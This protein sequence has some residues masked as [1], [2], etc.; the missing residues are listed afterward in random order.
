MYDEYNTLFNL[1]NIN[2]NIYQPKRYT[3]NLY[4]KVFQTNLGEKKMKNTFLCKEESNNYI[5]RCY[6]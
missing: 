1:I 6:Y 5:L 3:Q 2:Y 4:I